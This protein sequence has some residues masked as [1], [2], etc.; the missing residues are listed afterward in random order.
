[1]APNAPK[2]SNAS[3]GSFCGPRRTGNATD[4]TLIRGFSVGRG[5]WPAAGV[6]LIRDVMIAAYLGHGPVAQA[7]IRP[8]PRIYRCSPLLRRGA[9]NTAFVPM[10]AKRLEAGDDPHGFCRRGVLGA[11]FRVLVASVIATFAMPWLVLAQAAGFRGDER[12]TLPCLWPHLL[13]HILFISLDGA[14]A[15]A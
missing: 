11:G 12:R 10:F 13:F 1:M 15:S 4:Q 7:Y 6:G 8:S 9:F 5:R 14:E 2:A 3:G